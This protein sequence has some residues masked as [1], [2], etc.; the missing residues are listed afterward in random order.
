MLI[1]AINIILAL[2]IVSSYSVVYVDFKFFCDAVLK[3]LDRHLSCNTLYLVSPRLCFFI[4]LRRDLCVYSDDSLTGQRV[5]MQTEQPTTY[6][7]P[8]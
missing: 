1:I 7:V 4:V 6:V 3:E 2:F 5:I 8:L